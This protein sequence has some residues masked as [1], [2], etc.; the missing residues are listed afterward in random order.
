MRILLILSTLIILVACA[1]RLD[2]KGVSLTEL[3]LEGIMKAFKSDCNCGENEAT[4]IVSCA[5]ENSNAE[6]NTCFEI[7]M[8]GKHPVLGQADEKP[9][10]CSVRRTNQNYSGIRMA[11]EDGQQI[12]IISGCVR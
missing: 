7:F 1:S 11:R 10:Y 3:E 8:D 9:L 2:I 5:G 12:A 4:L 6:K